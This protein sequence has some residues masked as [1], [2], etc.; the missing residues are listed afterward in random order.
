MRGGGRPAGFAGIAALLF[1]L[2]VEVEVR[3]VRGFAELPRLRADRHEGQ[4]RRHHECL[5]RAA[6]QHIEAPAIDIERHGAEAGDGVHHEDG[7]GFGDRASHGFHVV[8]RAGGG[9]R[10][11]HEYALGFGFGLERGFHL[12]RFH[13][14]PV[15][16]GDHVGIQAV[17]LGDI[18]PPLAEFSR[19]ADDDLVALA[20]TDWTPRHPWRR[21]RRRRTSLRRSTSPSLL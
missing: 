10:R 1:L 9:L 14:L 3:Q 20:R 15:G 18:R 12:L 2:Q 19:D 8:R 13:H 5:L 17:G 7:V 16:H 4:A 11:L 6:D 21:C